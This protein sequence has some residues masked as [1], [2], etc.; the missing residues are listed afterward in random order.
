MKKEKGIVAKV[1]DTMLGRK[2]ES[3]IVYYHE[4][5]DGACAAAIALRDIECA[6]VYP[7]N[8]DERETAKLE[9]I[10]GKHVV[11]VDFTFKNMEKVAEHA[12]SLVWI[13]HHKT[14]F[15]HHPEIWQ[16]NKIRGMRA[17]DLSAAMLAWKYYCLDRAVPDCVKLVDDYDMWRFKHVFTR[18][19]NEA[20]WVW[21][22][23]PLD[24]HWKMLLDNNL[25]ALKFLNE[26]GMI[27]L[28]T[29]RDRVESAFKHGL[30]KMYWGKKARVVNVTNDISEV[31]DYIVKEMGY[32][33]AVIWRKIGT[34]VVVSLRSKP[35]I[36][37]AKIAAVHGGGGHKNAAGFS[38]EPVSG[39]YLYG[40]ITGADNMKEAMK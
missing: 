37:V 39:S 8:Y 23:N 4:D 6:E 26:A 29:K 18:E 12:A 10:K 36:D 30:D 15:E 11:V 20:G 14:A 24:W 5:M 7:V 13:D 17:L 34:N 16:D 33:I 40:N 19:F 35:D 21:L 31:G 1:V 22:K 2:K 28:K 27:M 25:E 9:N 38:I 3:T 32:D